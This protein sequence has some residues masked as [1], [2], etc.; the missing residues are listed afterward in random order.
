[1]P[2]D[3]VVAVS[4]RLILA[5]GVG[6]VLG[7]LIGMSLMRRF[8]IDGVFYMMAAAAGLL[9]ILAAGRMLTSQSP[10]H[11]ARTFRIL[12]PQPT[13][14][15]HDPQDADDPQGARDPEAG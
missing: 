15:A 2:A 4:G 1:M 14:L 7:P 8:D 5:S 12:A 13:P 3:R 10:P 6:S 9:A 11:L